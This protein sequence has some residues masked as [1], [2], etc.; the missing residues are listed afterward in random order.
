[1]A[2]ARAK[3]L[4]PGLLGAL[5]LLVVLLVAGAAIVFGGLFPIAASSPH[6]GAVGWL[7]GESMESAVKRNAKGLAPPQ[8]SRAD[9]VIGAAHYKGMCQQCHGGPGAAREEFAEGLNPPPPDLTRGEAGEW[10]QAQVFWIVKNGI[11]MTAMPAFGKT[12]SDAD[13]W[14]IAAF[15]KQLPKV[16]AAQYAA[17]PVERE[18]SEEAGE[19]HHH[20]E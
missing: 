20:H 9:I 8:M 10:S 14:R 11:K 1:M 12:H 18:E 4:G 16:S 13:I 2:E 5:V 19:H 6:G 15:V 17:Y 7:I 3:G